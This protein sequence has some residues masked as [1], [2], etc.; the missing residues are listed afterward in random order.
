MCCP[1]CGGQMNVV[2]FIEPPQPD[3]IEALLTHCGLWQSRSA[4][5]PPEVDELVLE[6][7]AAYSG[8]LLS[9]CFAR[10][11]CA[12][13]SGAIVRSRMRRTSKLKANRARGRKSCGPYWVSRELSWIVGVG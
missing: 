8:N 10:F 3:V 6:L 12:F 9:V 13:V 5:A 4:R 1:E 2:S 7:D 11:R